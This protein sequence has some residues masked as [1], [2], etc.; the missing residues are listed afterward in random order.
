MRVKAPAAGARV[1]NSSGIYVI[2]PGAV[3]DIPDELYADAVMQ[4]CL[5]VEGDAPKLPEKAP[6]GDVKRVVAL[7]VTDGEQAE[8]TRQG[9]PKVSAVRKRLGS[10]VEVTVEQVDEAFE[11]LSVP[12]EG[13][14]G[15][16]N[17]Q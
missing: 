16:N 1:A 12:D 5:P 11:A 7:M 15:E 2:K 3:R 17:G 6:D 4:G 9:R 10:E 13:E 8:F 14:D